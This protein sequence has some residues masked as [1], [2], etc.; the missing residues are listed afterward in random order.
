MIDKKRWFYPI[1]ISKL[2][3]LQQ[4]NWMTRINLIFFADR[5]FAVYLRFNHTLSSASK[6]YYL[7]GS[8]C[9]YGWYFW[10]HN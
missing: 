1:K 3:T 4:Q 7:C 5:I 10:R 9:V 8:L 2:S 6:I